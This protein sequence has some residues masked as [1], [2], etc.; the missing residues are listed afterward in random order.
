MGLFDLLNIINDIG[1]AKQVIEE[2]LQEALSTMEGMIGNEGQQSVFDSTI[3]PEFESA[4]GASPTDGW[5]DV[6]AGEYMDFMGEIVGEGNNIM[7]AAYD[8]AQEI[9]AQTESYDED[10]IAELGDEAEFDL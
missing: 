7:Q 2:G 5:S 1:D 9:L 8:Y 6:D 10:A 4:A 3:A